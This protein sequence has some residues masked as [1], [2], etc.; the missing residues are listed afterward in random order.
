M[1]RPVF[2][3]GLG[4]GPAGPEGPVSTT[5]GP[6]GD[7]GLPGVNAVA[8]DT[9]TAAYVTTPSSATATA[10]ATSFVGRAISKVNSTA[11][12][13]IRHVIDPTNTRAKW[14]ELVMSPKWQTDKVDPAFFLGWNAAKAAG[15][16]SSEA[17]AAEPSIYMGFE[18]DYYD[19]PTS[20]TM[21]WYV[22]ILRA[23]LSGPQ[24][25]P[26]AFTAARDSNSDLTA[27][28]QIDIGSGAHTGSSPDRSVFNV[29]AG[30]DAASAVASFT[31]TAIVFGRDITT[32]AGVDI[33]VNGSVNASGASTFGAQVQVVQGGVTLSTGPGHGSVDLVNNGVFRWSLGNFHGDPAHYLFDQTNSR[34]HGE[35]LAGT[36]DTTAR[37]VF[38]SQLEALGGLYGKRADGSRCRLV[39]ANDGTVSTV[40]A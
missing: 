31:P 22:G 6:Q 26:F 12:T 11:A 39:L 18:A 2:A 7:P 14:Q 32:S 40:P 1:T 38:H 15:S 33:T 35:Y 9:A 10:L 4:T 25:R 19:G 16:A 8:N 37:S 21:E 27:S 13:T 5:P 17:A 34:I 36:S 20:R 30:A 23:N 29:I 28:V 24:F 3:R